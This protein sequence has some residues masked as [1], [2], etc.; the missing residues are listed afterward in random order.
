MDINVKENF[1]EKFKNYFGEETNLPIAFW[2]GNDRLQDEE[3]RPK[4][5]MCIIGQL[6]KIR[7]GESLSFSADSVSC[8]GGKTYCGFAEF[9]PGLANF[10]STG[11]ER[12]LKNSDIAQK[13]INQFPV[14]PAP[15]KY[16]SFKR[17]DQLSE[18]D[19]P[20]V[21]IFFAKPDV[22]SGLF[23]LAN[24]D[25]TD[26]QSTI[27]PFSSGC[28]SIVTFPYQESKKEKPKAV[29][30][31]FDVSA[32]PYVPENTLSL[33][34]PMKKMQDMITNMDESF[35]STDEWGKVKNRIR[36]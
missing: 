35:L 32:R 3:I 29:L 11:K 5:W 24:Y 15:A 8:G 22:L 1:I 13:V 26:L 14:Y 16:I 23:T 31:M 12:Y 27:V 28:G 9:V 7:K 20:E 18:E 33:A 4:N 25:Q 21:V 2:Y 10:L 30:G 36:R 6:N 19:E 34:I 17:W